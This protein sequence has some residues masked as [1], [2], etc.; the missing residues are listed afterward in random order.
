MVVA[1]NGKI[2][3]IEMFGSPGL[4]DKVKAKILKGFVLDVI[5]VKDEGQAPPDKAAI[6]KFYNDSVKAQAEK[7]KDY[8]HNA[9]RKR[10][11]PDS[12]ANE[13]V[14]AEGMILHRSILAR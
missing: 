13:S 5:G 4:F 9:N 1:I 2:Q 10:A 12:I 6:V 11:N 8:K 14:D 7:L 3:A